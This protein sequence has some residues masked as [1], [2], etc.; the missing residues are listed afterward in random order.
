LAQQ[1]QVLLFLALVLLFMLL[2]TGVI[3]LLPQPLGS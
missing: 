2:L 1:G 3:P